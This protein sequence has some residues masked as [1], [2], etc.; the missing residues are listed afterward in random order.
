[1][2]LLSLS[3]LLRTYPRIYQNLNHI[4]MFIFTNLLLTLV[5]IIEILWPFYYQKTLCKI[6]K[7]KR[8]VFIHG[9]NIKIEDV[10][11]QKSDLSRLTINTILVL[12]PYIIYYGNRIIPR[13][14]PRI[15]P[16]QVKVI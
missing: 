9:I 3:L 1:M 4:K 16:I 13:R 15:S 5:A 7:L 8:I 14:K 2:S 6:L 12:I 10:K 11:I